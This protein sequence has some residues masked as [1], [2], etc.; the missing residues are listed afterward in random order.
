MIRIGSQYMLTSPHYVL[1]PSIALWLTVL[2]INR[3]GDYLQAK[4]NK[5]K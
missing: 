2:S 3:F 1:A 5:Q 4:L